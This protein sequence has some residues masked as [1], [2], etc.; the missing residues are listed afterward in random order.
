[1]FNYNIQEDKGMMN[2]LMNN[3]LNL[4]VVEYACNDPIGAMYR[5][6]VGGIALVVVMSIG[7]IIAT[8]NDKL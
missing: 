2:N 8:R 7:M 5:I 1:M 6:L 4:G 3:F